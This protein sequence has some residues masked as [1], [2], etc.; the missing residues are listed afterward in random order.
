MIAIHQV[1]TISH[2]ATQKKENEPHLALK[3]L[4]MDAVQK[5]TLLKKQNSGKKMS[6]CQLK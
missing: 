6:I 4:M 3:D 1:L 5:M 2:M